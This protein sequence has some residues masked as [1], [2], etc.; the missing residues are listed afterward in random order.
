MLENMDSVDWESLS[1]AYGNATQVP[2]ML[3]MLVDAKNDDQFQEIYAELMNQIN[4]QATVYS[5]TEPTLR[6]LVQMLGD[7][8][9]P[10]R[11]ILHCVMFCEL[12]RNTQIKFFPKTYPHFMPES[13]TAFRIDLDIYDTIASGLPYYLDFLTEDNPDIVA[14]GIYVLLYLVEESDKSISAI[15]NCIETTSNE[16][17]QAGG[18]WAIARIAYYSNQNF[19][20][21][22]D[23][24]LSWVQNEDSFRVRLSAAFGLLLINLRIGASFPSQLPDVVI[25]TIVES[26]KVKNEDFE[27]RNTNKMIGYM[28]SE[29]L[30]YI[31]NL[32]II[33]EYC[34]RTSSPKL[35]VAI[36][37]NLDLSHGKAHEYCR[38]LI[39]IAF[40]RRNRSGYHWDNQSLL[41][42]EVESK[43]IYEYKLE[44]SARL[45]RPDKPLTSKQIEVLR[46]IIDCEAFWQIPTNLFSFYYGLPDD[47]EALSELIEAQSS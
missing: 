24:L 11:K 13:I 37:Q 17:V 2:H 18:A 38:E 35:W 43:V 3:Q 27:P 30:P 42:I 32:E 33:T 28:Q 21:H 8:K 9:N 39:D 26:L 31:H 40:A 1:T 23:T 12:L 14:A 34:R 47:R 16:W 44:T 6:F 45:F 15:L 29:M 41:H 4:H 46:A 25:K 36:L 10:F 5:A 22:H 20:T 19:S 7:T